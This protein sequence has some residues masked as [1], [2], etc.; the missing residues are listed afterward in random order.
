MS[1]AD[2]SALEDGQ[3]LLCFDGVKM[4]AAAY[5][6][7]QLVGEPMTDQFL[8]WEF[9]VTV[10]AGLNTLTVAFRS[11]ISCDG[12]WMACSGGWAEHMGGAGILAACV[13]SMRNQHGND[14][15]S[16]IRL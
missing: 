8:R 14:Q 3:V 6:N 16:S 1:P 5:L 9:G 15:A 7:G 12:R 2:L 10:V 13:A 4:G 11:D